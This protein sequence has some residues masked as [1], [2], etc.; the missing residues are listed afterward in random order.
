MKEKPESSFVSSN[1]LLA[2]GAE[3]VELPVWTFLGL[4]Y[5]IEYC[6]A[7]LLY[8]SMPTAFWLK[9]NV[10]LRILEVRMGL[11]KFRMFMLKRRMRFLEFRMFLNKFKMFGL[12]RLS[13]FMGGRDVSLQVRQLSALRNHGVDSFDHL[14]EFHRI[15]FWSWLFRSPKLDA[16]RE[17]LTPKLSHRRQDVKA[18]SQDKMRERSDRTSNTET[19]RRL[20]PAPG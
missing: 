6:G 15:S 7:M 17:G 9:R 16:G 20:A 19:G 8:W 11:L 18:Q 2:R 4:W 14:G 12:G 1:D 13:V 10:L 5:R 3:P